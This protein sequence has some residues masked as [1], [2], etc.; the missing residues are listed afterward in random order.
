MSM[1]IDKSYKFMLKFC[2]KFFSF[3]DNLTH[4]NYSAAQATMSRLL[5]SI[6]TG[7]EQDDCSEPSLFSTKKF[8][9]KGKLR[10]PSDEMAAVASSS[11]PISPDLRKQHIANVSIYL[12][13]SSILRSVPVPHE[14]SEEFFKSLLR[15]G[16]VTA[17][18]T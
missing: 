6:F 2:C 9:L 17:A 13:G 5:S 18:K 4:Y 1:L 15:E 3:L 8:K 10:I 7:K 14:K 16:N 12:R 11:S